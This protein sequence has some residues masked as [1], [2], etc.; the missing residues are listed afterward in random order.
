[1]EALNQERHGRTMT[2]RVFP[3]R[4]FAA[5]ATLLLAA[6]FALA[7]SAQGQAKPAPDNSITP[8]PPAFEVVSVRPAKPDCSSLMAG[9]AHG[10]Y[11]ARCVTLWAL[12]FN[13]YE[14]RSFQDHPPGLPAW[15]DKD[16]F[17]IEA[18]ADD[19]TTAAMEKLPAREQGPM[20]REMLQ[21]LLADRFKFRV[22]YESKVQPVY[23]LVLAKGGFKLKP[24][25]ADQKPG[26]M[27]GGPGKMII[28]GMPIAAFAHFLSQTNLAGRIVVDKT[29]LT[30][31][32][33][34]DLKWT[35]DDQQ[36]TPDEGPTIFTALEEQLGLKLVPAKGPVH[37][38]VV[39]HVE[40]PSEN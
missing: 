6:S 32:Y 13:T 5:T 11:T 16:E 29:G 37:T 40:R 22:H 21:S 9:P 10:R 17:D 35:P 2:G 25:P 8:K 1:M 24:L 34:I 4:Q 27:S 18:K 39:D 7:A 33:D 19:D 31:N 28:H 3:P 12:I 38:L 14:V 26:V 36:G 30:G 15:A 23:E 20:G